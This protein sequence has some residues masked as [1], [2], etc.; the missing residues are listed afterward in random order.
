MVFISRPI[1]WLHANAFFQKYPEIPFL[2]KYLATRGPKMRPGTRTCI[3]VKK[4][5]LISVNATYEMSWANSFFLQKVPE[6]PF[7]PNLATRGPKM[8]LGNRKMDRGQEIRPIRVNAIC[9][10][11]IEPIVFFFKNSG[12]LVDRRT[13]GQTDGETSG[14][15][16]YTHI[17][18]SVELG[19]NYLLRY[20]LIMQH[21]PIICF[22]WMGHHDFTGFYQ[23]QPRCY[24]K[25]ASH[26][27]LH[28]YRMYFKKSTKTHFSTIVDVLNVV[29][30]KLKFKI[31]ECILMR[32][33]WCFYN[34][35]CYHA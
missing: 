12:N 14:W 24:I 23:L 15:I 19:F 30:N 18:P 9:M 20:Y 8:R 33:L 6:T 32:V 29:C 1:S 25:I 13:D 28:R 10:K 4:I 22:I 16:Q 2:A 31:I 11:W 27:I 7:R 26:H 3:E 35:L 5:H 34:G 17:P 21:Q